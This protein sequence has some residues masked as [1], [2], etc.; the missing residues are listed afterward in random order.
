MNEEEVKIGDNVEVINE[1]YMPGNDEGPLIKEGQRYPVKN[2][3]K[4]KCGELHVDIGLLS[5]LN[6]VTCYKCGEE[7]PNSKF[8][9]VH[10]CHSSRF[11]TVHKPETSEEIPTTQDC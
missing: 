1:A 11:M 3:Y 5:H 10:W 8:G 4:C 9:G 6:Y 2:T 7:L